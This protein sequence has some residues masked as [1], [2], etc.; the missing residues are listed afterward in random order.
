M[1]Y[2]SLIGRR[3]TLSRQNRLL[4]NLTTW[5][6]VAGVALGVA[7]LVVVNAVYDGYIAEIRSAF[8]TAFAHVELSGRAG[9]GGV[10]AQP[11]SLARIEAIPGVIAVAPVIKREALLLP[12]SALS[13]RR[14]GAIVLG[15]DPERAARVTDLFGRVV[16]GEVSLGESEALLGGALA[17]RLGVEVGDRLIALTDID[18]QEGRRPRAERRVLRVAGMF[19]SGFHEFDERFL[20]VNLA[21]ARSMYTVHPDLADA[22]QVRVADPLRADETARA[23][24]DAM[25]GAIART[26]DRHLPGFFAQVEITRVAVLIILLLLVLVASANVIGSLVMMVHD[27]TRDIGILRAMGA[28]RMALLRIFLLTGGLIGALGVIV[29]VG[30]GSGICWLLTQIDLFEIPPSVYFIDHLPI[31]IDG[32]KLGIVCLVT[33]LICLGA[34]VAPALRAAHLDPVEALRY[35]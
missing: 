11:E 3:I 21:T 22:M 9:P 15:V 2:P 5:I 4:V 28:T 14:A 31:L 32:V 6:A 8:M 34:S 30:L 20:A 13:R 19:E 1:A 26:W 25:P 23:I 16:G 17:E 24:V 35:E 29:G 12:R 18:T 33:F 27:R 7:S 10:D